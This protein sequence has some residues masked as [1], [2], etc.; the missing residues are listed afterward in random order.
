MH[1]E[2]HSSS[3]SDVDQ[4]EDLKTTAIV[5][6]V[7]AKQATS[8][9]YFYHRCVRH[10]QQT[11]WRYDDKKTILLIG[12]LLRMYLKLDSRDLC[13][14]IQSYLVEI[15]LKSKRDIWNMVQYTMPLPGPKTFES[16]R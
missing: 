11:T 2:D 3:E 9:I 14:L 16:S 13:G 7:M 15:N 10:W 8:K 6:A 12:G 5:N 1:N 4:V